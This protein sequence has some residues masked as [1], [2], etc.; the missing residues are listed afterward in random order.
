M[1]KIAVSAQIFCQHL[2]QLRGAERADIFIE[3]YQARAIP[4]VNSSIAWSNLEI[5]CPPCRSS[6]STGSELPSGF[7]VTDV[8]YQFRL[9]DVAC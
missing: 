8:V 4:I 7:R 3:Q 6:P 5:E 1:R 2:L 9:L